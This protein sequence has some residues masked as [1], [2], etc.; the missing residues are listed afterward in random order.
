MTRGS[1]QG[2]PSKVDR[3]EFLGAV[4]AVIVTPLVPQPAAPLKDSIFLFACVNTCE[5]SDNRIYKIRS[6]QSIDAAHWRGVYGV[7]E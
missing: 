5:W 7:T 4:L 6:R 2:L 1:A 3:R